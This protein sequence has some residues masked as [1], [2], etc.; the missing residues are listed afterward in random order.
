[1]EDRILF[2][3]IKNALD[4]LYR[5]DEVLFTKNDGRGVCERCLT[6]RFGYYLQLEFN[7]YF[8]DCDYNSSY[9]IDGIEQSEKQVGDTKRFI[10]II[11]HKRESE[12]SPVFETINGVPTFIRYSSDLICFEVKKWNNKT[13]D[14]MEKDD[15]NL[16]KLTRDYGYK[17]GFHLILGKT[18]EELI[19][20]KYD[21]EQNIEELNLFQIQDNQ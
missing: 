21:R 18:R 14:G 13:N 19:L 17:Y 2:R 5:I 7:D 12:N 3:K 1:M 4:K 11:I 6:F 8:V 20:K 15:N 16:K 9:N 10:D